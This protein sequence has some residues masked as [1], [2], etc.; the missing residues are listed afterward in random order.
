MVKI[1]T[2]KNRHHGDLK[3]ALVDAGV[4][5]L[6]QG[7]SSALTLRGCAT[8]A[9]V[10]HA[11]PAYHFDGFKGLLTAIVTQG[12]KDF[13]QEMIRQRDA[14]GKD[15]L[16]RLIAIGDGYLMFAKSNEAMAALMFMKNKILSDDPEYQAASAAS[17]KVLAEACVPFKSNGFSQKSIE[18]LIWSLIQG[19]SNLSRSGQVDVLETPFAN[20]LQL[21][22][23]NE[24]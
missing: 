19:Y 16:A 4:K 20:I 9:G 17:Y 5:L 10:S 8:S 12:F 21:L 3:K 13:T 11:A 14:A 2:Q 15:P 6:H 18:V 22:N 7:G 23:L 24:Q 1:N